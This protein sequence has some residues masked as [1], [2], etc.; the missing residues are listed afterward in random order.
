[1]HALLPVWLLLSL[2]PL[3]VQVQALALT[4]QN[5]GLPHR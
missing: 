1:M 5:L 2:L 4:H 3:E